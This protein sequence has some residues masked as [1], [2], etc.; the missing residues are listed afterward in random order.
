MP[1]LG[2]GSFQLSAPSFCTRV[3][4]GAET[5]LDLEFISCSSLDK[6]KWGGTIVRAIGRGNPRSLTGTYLFLFHTIEFQNSNWHSACLPDP[7]PL[8]HWVPV[9]SWAKSLACGAPT[10]PPGHN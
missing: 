1:A 6:S 8:L 3:E 4:L 5:C 10:V 9:A 7:A 2:C